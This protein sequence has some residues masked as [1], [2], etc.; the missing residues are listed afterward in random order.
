M[1]TLKLLAVAVLIAVGLSVGSTTK[2]FD[3]DN[4]V[5]GT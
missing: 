4:I 1:K 2:Y 5:W 3:D